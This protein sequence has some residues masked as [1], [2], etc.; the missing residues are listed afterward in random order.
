MRKLLETMDKKGRDSSAREFIDLCKEF[1][2]DISRLTL[3]QHR[4]LEA[5][6]KQG[7]GSSSGTVDKKFIGQTFLALRKGDMATFERNGGKV[8]GFGAGDND[9]WSMNIPGSFTDEN[10]KALLGSAYL[11]GDAVTGSYLV[12]EA[13]YDDVM[14]VALQGSV[15]ASRVRK[16]E[17]TTRIVKIPNLAT[18]LTLA[19]PTD[20]TTTKTESAPTFGANLELTAKTCA[21]WLSVTDELIEDSVVP[22]A[23]LFSE[24]YAEAWGKEIDTQILTANAAPFT[25]ILHC[26]SCTGVSLGAG[27]TSYENLNLEALVDLE[28][29]ISVAKGEA[30]LAGAVFIMHRKV[31][32]RLKRLKD[33]N[34]DPIFM[35]AGDG[36]P[37][38]IW[39]YPY[40]LSDVMPY[41]TTASTPFL[42]LGNPKYWSM[43]ERVGMEI[44]RFDQTSYGMQNDQIFYRFRIRAAFKEL[45]P[46]AFAVLSTGA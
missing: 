16:I 26:A 45:V 30:A 5:T 8:G 34:G 24:L 42:I 28:D 11:R 3:Q 14:R 6:V 31:F 7:S 12:P 44:K 41:P 19:W 21:G 20:E 23:T 46:A 10:M 36:I 38:T 18:M 25:G 33:D 29:A 9:D 43:G 40:I 39:N 27:K 17:M 13:W 32:N 4:I 35:K 22:L 2:L 15:M 37:A 1:D